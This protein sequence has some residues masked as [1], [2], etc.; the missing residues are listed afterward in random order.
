MLSL[1]LTRRQSLPALGKG[2]AV[3]IRPAR[4]VR[5]K[6]FRRDGPVLVE[7]GAAD[8]M[9]QPT[10]RQRDQIKRTLQDLGFTEQ[11]RTHGFLNRPTSRIL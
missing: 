11:A 8:E 1:Q 4:A 9:N 10:K 2:R 5:A 6:L 7:E 3:T